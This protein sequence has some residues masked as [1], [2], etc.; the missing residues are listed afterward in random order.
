MQRYLE[1]TVLSSI[2]GLELVAK[3]VVD[4][5]IAGLHRSPTFG[6]STE[7]AEYRAYS[8]GDDPRRIDW[9]VFAR[10]ERAYIKRFRG[11]TNTQIT[12]LLDVS[13]SMA[14]SSH[15]VSKIEYAKYLAAS[16]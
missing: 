2:S 8:E 15:P 13:A 9:N 11:E 12:I 7:F 6:F 5:F 1:P 4:G 14:Y 16:L 3:T 10:T